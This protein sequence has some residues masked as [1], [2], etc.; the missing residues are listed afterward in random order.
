MYA[1]Q[2]FVQQLRSTRELFNRIQRANYWAYTFRKGNPT[3]AGHRLHDTQLKDVIFSRK[4][5]SISELLNDIF[6]VPLR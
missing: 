4:W 5:S 2:I 1:Q 3:F 6:L